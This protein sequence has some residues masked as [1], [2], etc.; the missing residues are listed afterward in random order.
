MKL[1][2]KNIRK[3]LD[4]GFMLIS[5]RE[6]LQINADGPRYVIAAMTAENPQWHTLKS[7]NTPAERDAE[8]QL[9]S[10]W[11]NVLLVSR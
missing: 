11:S 8:I 4:A 6:Y 3:L 7:F 1:S 9:M 10:G 2:D 5:E